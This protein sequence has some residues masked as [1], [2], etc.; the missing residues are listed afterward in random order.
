MTGIGDPAADADF[1]AAVAE[2]RGHRVTRD[3]LAEAQRW[4]ARAVEALAPLPDG[5]VKKALTKFAEAIV[6]RTN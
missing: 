5:P 2:L 6:E 3:T 4:A 1:V